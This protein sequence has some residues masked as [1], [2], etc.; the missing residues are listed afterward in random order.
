MGVGGDADGA[1]FSKTLEMCLRL[2]KG[3][4]PAA[5]ELTKEE[6]AEGERLAKEYSR[7]WVRRARAAR[8]RGRAAARRAG[9]AAPARGGGALGAAPL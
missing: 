4:A 3:E 8:N 6:L 1:R 9:T 7:R 5:P 2:L